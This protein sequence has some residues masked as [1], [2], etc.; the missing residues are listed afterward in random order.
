MKKLTKILSF[1][2][3]IIFTMSNICFATQAKTDSEKAKLEIVE[4][5]ICKIK[6]NDYSKFE[7]RL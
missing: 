1:L 2:F 4:D 7:K 6:I 3:I 5:N